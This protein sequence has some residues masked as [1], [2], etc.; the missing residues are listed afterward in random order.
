[1][2]ERIVGHFKRI[3]QPKANSVRVEWPEAPA[4]QT[5]SKLETVYAGDILHV[6]D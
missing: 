6:F 5:P 1:M 2:S 3:D 4:S